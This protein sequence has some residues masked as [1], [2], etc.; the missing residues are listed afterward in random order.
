MNE[1]LVV[2]GWQYRCKDDKYIKDQSIITKRKLILIRVRSDWPSNVIKISKQSD[3]NH[4][5]V[6]QMGE[7][8]DV[9][10]VPTSFNNTSPH[11]LL[12][13]GRRTLSLLS[14]LIYDC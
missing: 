5:G 2:S 9:S 7:S 10:S 13:P 12:P 3:T 4:L 8:G 1:M 6:L 14:T 11:K